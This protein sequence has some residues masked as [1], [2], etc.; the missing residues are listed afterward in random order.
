MV[1][2]IRDGRLVGWPAPDAALRPGDTVVA[3]GEP[4]GIAALAALL[5]PA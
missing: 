2:L 1:A 3:V 5:E 4:D